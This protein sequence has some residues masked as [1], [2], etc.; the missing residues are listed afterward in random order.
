MLLSVKQYAIFFA[1][2]ITILVSTLGFKISENIEDTRQIIEESQ[3][4]AAVVELEHAISFT[5]DNIKKSADSLSRWQEVKQQIHNPDIFAY[6]YSVRFKK[7]AFDLQKFTQELMIY[8]VNGEALDSL[9]GNSL[10]YEIDISRVDTF[11]F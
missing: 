11:L 9:V 6:W 3:K 4:N 2:F 5:L 8:D 10:P 1:L 7:Y